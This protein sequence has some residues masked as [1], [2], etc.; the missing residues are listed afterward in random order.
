MVFSIFSTG[1]DSP[2]PTAGTCVSQLIP[3]TASKQGQADSWGAEQ[4]R[5]PPLPLPLR[6]V[7]GAPRASSGPVPEPTR[8]AE[9]PDAQ[10]RQTDRGTPLQCA[11][12]LWHPTP[13]LP[14]P[15]HTA[16]LLSPRCPLTTQHPQELSSDQK[17]VLRTFPTATASPLPDFTQFLPKASPDLQDGPD[18]A[19]SLWSLCLLN[20]SLS[21]SLFLSKTPGSLTGDAPEVPV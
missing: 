1:S 14:C 2:F 9:V 20:V 4:R 13:T 6:P 15:S 11:G 8:V 12:P 18:Q 17:P 19:T 16:G 10:D 5:Q 7:S 21:L 3:V